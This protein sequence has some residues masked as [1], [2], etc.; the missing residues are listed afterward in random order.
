MGTDCDL[1]HE[2]I[3]GIH[4]TQDPAP[5]VEIHHRWQQLFPVFGANDAHTDAAFRADRKRRVL[6]TC[7]GLRCRD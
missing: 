7:I 6:D 5:T 4:V 2:A 1:A 3:M